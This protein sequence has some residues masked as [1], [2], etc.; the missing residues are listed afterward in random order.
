VPQPSDVQPLNAAAA[1]PEEISFSPDGAHLVVT[2]KTSNTVDVFAVN[3]GN[4]GPAVTTTLAGTGPYGFAFT[5]AGV[6]V[7]SESAFGGLGSFSIS[8][9]GTL[10]QISQV[11]DGQL[12]AC[13]VALSSDG[14][15]AY[16]ANA[17]SGTVSFYS[18][19][20]DGTLTLN[21]PAIATNPGPGDTD[22]A[23]SGHNTNLNIFDGNHIDTAAIAPNGTLGASNPAIVGLAAGT[24]GLAATNS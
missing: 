22:L 19:A 18:V 21:N 13:W 1:S 24:E 23:V 4:V 6:A 12:A 9:S 17:H 3:D 15:D 20:P 16:T 7:I 11:S 14:R 8:A 5:P 10:Q 2:E